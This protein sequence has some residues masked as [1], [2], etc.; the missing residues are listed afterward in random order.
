MTLFKAPGMNARVDYPEIRLRYA[1]YGLTRNPFPSIAVSTYKV[2]YPFLEAIRHQEVDTFK[3][4]LSRLPLDAHSVILLKG[5][6]GNGKSALL[7]Y[8]C[9]VAPS[10]VPLN[11]TSI[12]T[13]LGVSSSLSR[14]YQDAVWWLG[15]SFFPLLAQRIIQKASR[16]DL[17]RLMYSIWRKILKPCQNC[18]YYCTPRWIKRLKAIQQVFH[19]IDDEIGA[20][21]QLFYSWITIRKGNLVTLIDLMRIAGYD[22]VIIGIDEI[23]RRLPIFSDIYWHLQQLFSCTLGKIVLVCTADNVVLSWF[24]D[25]SYS[26]PPIKIIEVDK[27]NFSETLSLVSY[28]LSKDRTVACPEKEQIERKNHPLSIFPFTEEAVKTIFQHSKNVRDILILCHDTLE[29]SS[30]EGLP[31]I[32]R[33]EVIRQIK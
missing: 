33:S 9:K 4:H 30:R 10:L 32:D 18:S 12:Y 1:A 25:S 11:V 19:S 26:F 15:P 20:Y 29:Y 27:F 28:Y 23:E 5:E 22:K 31:Q 17:P 8:L 21:I 13:K 7:K 2:E 14:P 6:S 3:I 24:R 16:K